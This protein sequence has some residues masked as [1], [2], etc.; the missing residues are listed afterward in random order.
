MRTVW[1]S[2]AVYTMSETAEERIKAPPRVVYGYVANLD[3]APVWRLYAIGISR[4]GKGPCTAGERFTINYDRLGERFS[5]SYV[6]TTANENQELEFEMVNGNV[7]VLEHY[8]FKRAGRHTHCTISRVSYSGGA[9]AAIKLRFVRYW[10]RIKLRKR[11]KRN[12]ARLCAGVETR[13]AH[14]QAAD[15]A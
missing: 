2:V 1:E 10:V 7:R 14:E 12:A 11:V 9:L 13:P 6:V 15:V 8:Q 3:L 4:D 5:E